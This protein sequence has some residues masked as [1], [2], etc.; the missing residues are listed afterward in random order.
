MC[1]GLESGIISKMLAELLHEYFQYNFIKQVNKSYHWLSRWEIDWRLVKPKKVILITKMYSGFFGS[2]LHSWFI[3]SIQLKALREAIPLI[4][5]NWFLL[6][7]GIWYHFKSASGSFLLNIFTLN[8]PAKESQKLFI[9]LR[10][11]W[12]VFYYSP[13][14]LA[15]KRMQAVFV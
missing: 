4:L 3:F 15:C 6:W 8:K 9:R 12:H 7:I 11:W 1:F 13:F 2:S 10:H 14:S 5:T